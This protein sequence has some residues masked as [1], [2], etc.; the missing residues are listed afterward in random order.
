MPVTTLASS[1]VY[2]P[3]GRSTIV[4][5][6]P[7][8]SL[9][10]A[11]LPT[12]MS[13][14]PT[15]IE[16]PYCRISSTASSTDSTKMSVSALSVVLSTNSDSHSSSLHLTSGLIACYSGAL[17]LMT[18]LPFDLPA[19]TYSIASFVC[20]NGNTLSITGLI[21]PASISLVIFASWSPC[22]SINKNE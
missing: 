12:G 4:R 11:T 3:F 6:L 10:T 1:T 20:E 18:T 13:S 7:K 9:M 14:G 5:T 19:S 17:S 2:V 15:T 8:G 22:A 16:P 21:T